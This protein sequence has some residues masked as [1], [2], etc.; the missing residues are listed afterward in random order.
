MNHVLELADVAGPAVLEQALR[1]RFTELDVVET[2]LV[3]EN[4][5]EVRG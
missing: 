3:L 2:E 1:R 4:A 5:Q